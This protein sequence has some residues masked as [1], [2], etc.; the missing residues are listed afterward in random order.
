MFSDRDHRRSRIRKWI[1]WC[2]ISLAF[3]ATTA[4]ANGDLDS[5]G[6]PTDG[7]YGTRSSDALSSWDGG[8]AYARSKSRSGLRRV[9]A[10]FPGTAGEAL[11][12]SYDVD[13]NAARES[14][15]AFGIVQNEIR[16]LE[17]ACRAT[18]GCS[19]GE[20]DQAVL[21]YYQSHDLRLTM[22]PGQ[23]PKLFVDIPQV[24]RRNRDAVRPVVAA[25]RELG[26]Q[27]GGDEAWMLEAAVALV[28]TGLEYRQPSDVENGR[29]TLGFYTP[30]RALEQGF[31]DC[32]TK[33]ALLA[34]ILSDL[35]QSGIVGV[36]VPG[37][38]LLGVER[39]PKPGD[40]FVTWEGR[41]Y[42][43]IEAAGPAHRPPGQV[44]DRT[45]AAIA[46]REPM[47]IDPI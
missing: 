32:D 41:R 9:T 19:Q 31:G 26:A 20:L 5:V 30:A 46:A 34:A 7:S 24:V 14:M 4:V 18:K 35:G 1:R 23:R 3:V 44:S 15:Q 25:L 11:R 43:L 27:R 2:A 10:Q 29:Q 36:R 17:N 40:A 13:A 6:L 8:G 39:E 12:V 47:R 37:H 21:R 16:S 33:S 45:R 22:R 28:Q 38:Y 42:V